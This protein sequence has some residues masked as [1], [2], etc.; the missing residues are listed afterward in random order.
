MRTISLDRPGAF[1]LVDTPEPARP[2]PDEALI[3][4]KRV[5]VCGTDLHAFGGR[6]PFF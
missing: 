4:I 1:R 2:G 6:Q 5:G 3:E